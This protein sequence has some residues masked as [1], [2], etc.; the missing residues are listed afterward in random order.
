MNIKALVWGIGVIIGLF[1]LV[2]GLRTATRTM[3]NGNDD[4]VGVN[5]RPNSHG[6]SEEADFFSPDAFRDELLK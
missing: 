5:F 4:S 1:G 2:L 3:G 6:H